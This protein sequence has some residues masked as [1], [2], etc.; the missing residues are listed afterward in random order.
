[1]ENRST[2]EEEVPLEKQIALVQQ[3]DQSIQNH[4]LKVY[5]PF[6][7]KSVS[8]VCKRYIDP[9][10][11]DEFSVGLIAFNEAMFSYS[12]DKGSTFLSFAS[13]VVKRKVIDYIRKEQT[14]PAQ[15]SLD[16]VYD[17]DNMTV[18][19]LEVKAAKE[20]Y[21][22]Q[23]ESWH[24]SEEIKDLEQKLKEYK[25]SFEELTKISP[26]HQDARESAIRTAKI[27]YEDES[28]RDFVYKKKKIPIKALIEK[29]SVSKKTLERN[30]KYILAIFVILGGEYIYLKDYLKGV[31]D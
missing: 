1:M 17:E 29:V 28:M 27:L 8:Q 12:N 7:A 6:I 21:Q 31:G 11:D 2:E 5:Q 14:N 26:K 9:N 15:A 25:L 10:T 16:E 3:G 4:L 13:L 19:P 18:N 23:S 22:V 20:L 24:R 30:R